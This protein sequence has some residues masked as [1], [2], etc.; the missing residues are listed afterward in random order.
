MY[1]S[2]REWVHTQRGMLP[3]DPITWASYQIHKIAGCACAG[4]VGVVSPATDFKW[5]GWLAIPA[6]ITTR[7]SRTCRVAYRDRYSGDTQLAPFPPCQVTATDTQNWAYSGLAYLP[8]YAYDVIVGFRSLMWLLRQALL[9]WKD[10]C[11]YFLCWRF[12]LPFVWMIE[13]CQEIW[14]YNG[15]TIYS[16]N[17]WLLVNLFFSMNSH[18]TLW[19][20]VLSV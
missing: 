20:G 10:T 12:S 15:C 16:I 7:A 19:N 1:Y 2:G 18:L 17:E 13:N 9:F 4:N 11:L 6:C 8:G 3:C 14:W 5:K